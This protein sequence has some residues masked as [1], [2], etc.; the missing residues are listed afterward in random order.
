MSKLTEDLEKAHKKVKELSSRKNA[1]DKARRKRWTGRFVIENRK[2]IVINPQPTELG[3]KELAKYN[4]EYLEDPIKESH[5]MFW[6]NPGISYTPKKCFCMV[7]GDLYTVAWIQ[8]G[9]APRFATCSK[10]TDF[11]MLFANIRKIS[12][13]K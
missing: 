11:L 10:H 1:L 5:D 13:V 3:L 8:L 12:A 2:G 6:E 4:I 9:I 7:C